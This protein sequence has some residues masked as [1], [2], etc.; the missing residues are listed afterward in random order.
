M[1]LEYQ[2]TGLVFKS[3]DYIGSVEPPATVLEDESRW[4]NDG[5]ITGA[6]WTQL[7][8][9][10]W[11]LI[12][13]GDDYITFTSGILDDLTNGTI[14]GWFYLTGPGTILSV[15]KDAANHII[16]DSSV[17]N[18]TLTAELADA[19]QFV[20]S[21]TDN[22]MTEDA[23]HHFA[24]T[25]TGTTHVIYIDGM[26]NDIT[27]ADESD[28]SYYFNDI[29]ATQLNKIGAAFYI[30]AYDGYIGKFRIHSRALSAE[31]VSTKIPAEKHWFGI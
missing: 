14:E 13:D 26:A 30:S 7:P 24:W 10:L 25:K 4:G 16:L 11:V 8:S 5:T 3:R 2:S 18:V 23:W 22:N 20:G 6:T 17:N 29:P 28:L 9:G 27:W 15:A 31:E 12:F 1:L 19:D 21:T